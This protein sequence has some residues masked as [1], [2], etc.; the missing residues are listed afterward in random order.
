MLCT[1]L[2]FNGSSVC[3]FFVWEKKITG[4]K[5][6]DLNDISFDGFLNWVLDLRKELNIPHK[7]SEVID[8]KDFNIERLSKMAIDDPS[9]GGNPKKLTIEDMRIMY[10]HSMKGKLFS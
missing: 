7:L 1:L 3:Y 9:T 4:R 10:Q 5:Y 2:C 8:E 6:L